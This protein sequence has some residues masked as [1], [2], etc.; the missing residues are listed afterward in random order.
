MNSVNLLGRITHSLQLKK[1]DKG[2]LYCPFQIAVDRP[3]KPA[4]DG[5]KPSDFIDCVAW[6]KTAESLVR[7]LGKGRKVAITGRLQTQR[8][9][10]SDGKDRKTVSVMVERFEFADSRREEQGEKGYTY[11]E[12]YSDMR[13]EDTEPRDPYS[14]FVP[15]DDDGDLPF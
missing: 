7:Y 11:S 4:T 6:N 12:E 14:A 5:T 1:T 15:V 2:T 10:D 3:V 8:W 9:K 13:Y